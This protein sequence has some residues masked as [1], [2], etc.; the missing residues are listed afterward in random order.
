MNQ[1]GQLGLGYVSDH[2]DGG[3]DNTFVPGVPQGM[4]S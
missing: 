3:S 1:Y 4:L 2:V